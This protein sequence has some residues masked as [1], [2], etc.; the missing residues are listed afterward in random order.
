MKLEKVREA[1]RRRRREENKGLLK[2]WMER[3]HP[4]CGAPGEVMSFFFE[5]VCTDRLPVFQWRAPY[6]RIYEQQELDMVE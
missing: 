2:L 1:A 6:S 3:S 5:I 4:I